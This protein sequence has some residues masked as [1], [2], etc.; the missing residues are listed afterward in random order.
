MEEGE[1]QTGIPGRCGFPL[2]V[3]IVSVGEIEQTAVVDTNER[4]A[5]VNTACV[6]IVGGKVVVVT[7]AVL[8]TGLTPTETELEFVHPFDIFQEGL[9]V[10]LPTESYRGECCPVLKETAGTV[11]TDGGCNHIT[12]E[13]NIVGTSEE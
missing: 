9:F 6:N 1:V 3:L 4:I 8:L 13:G 11:A 12:V 2:Q 7:D 10:D 5:T